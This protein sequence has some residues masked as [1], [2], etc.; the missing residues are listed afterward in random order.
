M[1]CSS[2]KILGVEQLPANIDQDILFVGTVRAKKEK[3]TKTKI[4]KDECFVTLDVQNMAVEF[5]VDTGSPANIPLLVY[6][7]LNEPKAPIQS[8]KTKA[9]QLNR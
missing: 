5:E 1:F 2:K 7:R 6:E 4:T 8:S 3:L 9:N